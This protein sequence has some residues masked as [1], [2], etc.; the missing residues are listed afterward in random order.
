MYMMKGR[1]GWTDRGT[2]GQNLKEGG[3]W[4]EGVGG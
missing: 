3:R 4:V 2:E 1:E